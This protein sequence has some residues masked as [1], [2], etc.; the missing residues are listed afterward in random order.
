MK[1]YQWVEEVDKG[2]GVLV[3]R[4]KGTGRYR[5]VSISGDRTGRRRQW[6]VRGGGYLKNEASVYAVIR[7]QRRCLN[8]KNQ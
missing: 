8:A 6:F 5:A 1:R 4:K 2:G 3:A 7:I